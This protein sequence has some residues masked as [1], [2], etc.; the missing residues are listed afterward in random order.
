[1]VELPDGTIFCVYYEEGAG[2]SIRATWFRVRADG[3]ARARPLAEV[4]VDSRGARTARP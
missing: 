2:S 3:I 4:A 1:M